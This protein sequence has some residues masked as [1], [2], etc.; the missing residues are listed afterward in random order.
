MPPRIFQYQVILSQQFDGGPCNH[1]EDKQSRGV[2]KNC[3]P[4]LPS[5]RRVL[6]SLDLPDANSQIKLEDHHWKLVNAGR[7]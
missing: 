6:K 2:L 4:T 5:V 1:S 7:R 3:T